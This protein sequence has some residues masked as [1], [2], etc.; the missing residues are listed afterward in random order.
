MGSRE[1]AG[2]QQRKEG[3]AGGR[4]LLFLDPVTVA[5]ESP[6]RFISDI[7]KDD[8]ANRSYMDKNSNTESSHS[9]ELPNF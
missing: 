3:G 1:G 2:E 9:S 5:N 6:R 7:S 4:K 8:F